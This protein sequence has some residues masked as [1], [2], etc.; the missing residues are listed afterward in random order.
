MFIPLAIQMNS[1]D[2]S[3]GHQSSAIQLN[4]DITTNKGTNNSAEFES[5]KSTDVQD[6]SCLAAA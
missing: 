2:S 6:I 5:W 3:S 1:G 4:S